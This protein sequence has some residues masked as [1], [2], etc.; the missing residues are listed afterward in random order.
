REHAEQEERA[1]HGVVDALHDQRRS[2]LRVEP[3]AYVRRA[4]PAIEALLSPLQDR[5]AA[6]D[7]LFVPALVRTPAMRLAR[8]FALAY[9]GRARVHRHPLEDVGVLALRALRIGF[10]EF[11][12]ADGA[13]VVE[14]H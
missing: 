5:I 10:A 11:L 3:V 13:Q 9:R 14:E 12:L 2:P 8:M 7:P 1:R 6:N 4:A